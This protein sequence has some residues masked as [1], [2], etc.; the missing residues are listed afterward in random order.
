ME[1][2]TRI[3]AKEMSERAAISQ[4][5]EELGTIRDQIARDITPNDTV[6]RVLQ[7]LEELGQRLRQALR[8]AI[9]GE[10]NSG[11]TSL[12]N[13]LIGEDVLVTDLLGNTR[14]SILI[15]HAEAP[16]LYLV[17]ADGTREAVT[18]KSLEVVRTGR[19]YSLELGLPSDRLRNV[20]IMDNPGLSP[21]GNGIARLEQILQQAD[22]AIWCT[23]AT[24]A[25]KQTESSLWS[26]AT[27][28][29]KPHSLL[30]AT[31]ADALSDDDKGRLLQRLQR[32]AV[33]QFDDIAMMSLRGASTAERSGL[34]ELLAK[35]DA[36][37][38]R[39]DRRRLQAAKRVVDRITSQMG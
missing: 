12:A 30:L 1:A 33:A 22:L 13:A 29:G 10:A 19:A 32:E 6:R 11:K 36:M 2:G 15:R 26:A 8:I 24:Q 27:Q 31:H 28:R 3:C 17:A 20:E 38:E 9:V 18:E 21:Q 25:W 23:L 14:A 34:G 16:A 35:I 39:A 7:I 4:F 37:L 5:L